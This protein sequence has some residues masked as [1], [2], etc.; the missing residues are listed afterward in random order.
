[1]AVLRRRR[2]GER[3]TEQ[4]ERRQQRRGRQGVD[5]PDQR[6]R[7]RWRA[8]EPATLS[9][10]R[11]TAKLKAT[12]Y[13][14]AIPSN[15]TIV[16]IKVKALVKGRSLASI[17]DSVKLLKAGVAVGTNHANGNLW[18]AALAN[19]TYG[20]VLRPLGN[21]VDAGRHQ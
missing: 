14:F 16:G 11:K 17:T 18:S 8:R 19:Q 10:R 6:L 5:E 12:G 3:R 2:S 21:D 15:A 1:M 7:C 9:L 13:G 4:P 20:S